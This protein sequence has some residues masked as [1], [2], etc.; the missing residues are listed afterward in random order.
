M[1]KNIFFDLDDTLLDFKGAGMY[2]CMF[3]PRGKA[4]TGNMTP[5]FEISKLR[6]LEKIINTIG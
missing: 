3:N 5:D 4:V 6:Q 2:T 1:I